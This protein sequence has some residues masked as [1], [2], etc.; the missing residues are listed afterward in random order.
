MI[1]VYI[2]TFAILTISYIIWK[3]K[4]YKHPIGYSAVPVVAGGWPIIGHWFEFSKDNLAFVRKARNKYGNIFRIKLFLRDMIVICDH[5]LKNEFFTATEDY[6]SLHEILNTHY[7]DQAFSD[8]NDHLRLMLKIIKGTIKIN[9]DNFVPKIM[10]EANKMIERLKLKSNGKPI[11]ISK[12]M[13][14]FVSNTSAR[15]FIGI[16]LTDQFYDTFIRFTNLLNDTIIKT[17]KYPKWILKLMV[18]Q[19]LKYYRNIMINIL[20][21]EIKSYR[22]DPTKNESMLIRYAVDYYDKKLNV[23]LSDEDIASIIICL[24]YVSSENTALAATAT[25]TDLST[26]DNAWNMV[27]DESARCLDTN[28]FRELLTSPILD[29]VVHESARLNSH[30]LGINRKPISKQATLGKY[31]VGDCD[32]IALC[33]PIMMIYETSPYKDSETYN[34]WRFIGNDPE[35]KMPQDIL[36]FGAGHHWCPG[37]NFALYEIKTIV[38]LFVTTFKQFKLPSCDKKVDRFSPSAYAD[39]NAEIIISPINI[40]DKIVLSHNYKTFDIRILQGADGHKGW[41]IKNCLCE[42]EQEEFYKYTIELS[43]DAKERAEIMTAKQERAFPITYYNLVYTGESNCIKPKRWLN[44][45]SYIWNML[46]DHSEILDFPIGTRIYNFDSVYCQLFGYGSSMA[47][48]KDQYVD[49]GVSISFGASCEF[50]FGKDRIILESGD[51]FVA[52]F[53]KVDHAVDRI[54]DNT[55]PEWWQSDCMKEM[56][57][58]RARCSI[59]IRD[60]THTEPHDYITDKEFK[61]LVQNY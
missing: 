24:L 56:T 40:M 33:T 21:P 7:F 29:A 8:N 51:V 59:Q 5:S 32:T 55:A 12:E 20:K 4:Q 49:W 43:K 57:F 1:F 46:L 22:N 31:Y 61:S 44:F 15:C 25:L 23:K 53:N 36:N 34:P 45:A 11:Q 38:T 10:D 54:I 13:I 14:R 52:D 3:N 39:I 37:R 6:L 50:T 17:F 35:S 47:L 30:V 9:F 2:I 42:R 60:L 41:L 16:E 19:K 18:N 48:H 27:V 26:N 28:N 58:N